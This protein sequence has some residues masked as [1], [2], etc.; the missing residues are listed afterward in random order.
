MTTHIYAVVAVIDACILTLLQSNSEAVMESGPTITGTVVGGMSSEEGTALNDQQ[1]Q[2]SI[3]ILI[4]QRP[5]RPISILISS[6]V[7]NTYPITP[8]LTEHVHTG[9]LRIST[10]CRLLQQFKGLEGGYLYLYN[11]QSFYTRSD[12]LIASSCRSRARA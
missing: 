9:R 8:C 5:S 4:M 7:R 11:V 12:G 10:C 3:F 2:V 6:K 1:K